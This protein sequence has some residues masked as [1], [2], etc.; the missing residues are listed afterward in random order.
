[1]NISHLYKLMIKTHL[2]FASSSLYISGGDDLLFLWVEIWMV[3]DAL[4]FDHSQVPEF[5]YQ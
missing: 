4:M 3:L 1:M 5:L 2:Y